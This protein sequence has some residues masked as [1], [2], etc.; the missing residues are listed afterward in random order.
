[1]KRFNFKLKGLLKIREVVEQKVKIEL[2]E[3]LQQ[4]NNL[5][6][7]IIVLNHDI[8]EG[9]KS[10]ESVSRN[11]AT[12]KMLEFYPYFLEGKRE[13][14]KFRKDQIKQLQV[15]YDEKIEQLKKARADVK[16]IE[17]LKEKELKKYNKEKNRLEAATIEEL[18]IMKLNQLL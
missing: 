13:H 12:A 14:I 6:D 16:L 5:R 10:Q 9:Y 4:I 2:G 7:E 18:N 3:I 8:S 17:K 15:K 1:M 11:H